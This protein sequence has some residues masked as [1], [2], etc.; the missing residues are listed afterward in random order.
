MVRR[1][2]ESPE[3]SDGSGRWDGH[4]GGE[5]SSEKT[6]GERRCDGAVGSDPGRNQAEDERGVRFASAVFD[7]P[8]RFGAIQGARAHCHRFFAWDNTEHRHGA[9]GLLTPHDAH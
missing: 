5:G 9:L 2:D 3:G 7:F 6:H 4:S 1:T 8:E